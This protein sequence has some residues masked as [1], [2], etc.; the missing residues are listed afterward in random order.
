[1]WKNHWNTT[2]RFKDIKDFSV[3]F[4]WALYT[5][6]TCIGQS[7]HWSINLKFYD[8]EI[9]ISVLIIESLKVVKINFPKKNIYIFI[10]YNMKI[11]RIHFS[12]SKTHNFAAS[13]I[14]QYW[15]DNAFV[16]IYF[17]DNATIII[18]WMKETN[19]CFLRIVS[20]AS[21]RIQ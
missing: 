3:S 16:M 13:I 5:A 2:A 20:K 12:W 14:T 19:S 21:I 1:M 18:Y 4:G 10:Y 11:W 17:S 8:K 15:L 7:F 6:Y 9:Y